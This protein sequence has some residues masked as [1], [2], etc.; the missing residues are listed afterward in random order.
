MASKN[1]PHFIS[2]EFEVAAISPEEFGQ[3]LPTGAMKPEQE[4]CGRMKSKK[5]KHTEYGPFAPQVKI[6]FINRSQSLPK[7]FI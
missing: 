2:K 1:L 3:E 7:D 5:K 4:I 6:N